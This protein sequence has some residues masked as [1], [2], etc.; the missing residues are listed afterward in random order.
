MQPIDHAY[1]SKYT[2]GNADLENEV[3]CL[4]AEQA[5]VY[6]RQMR[7]AATEKAWREAAHTLKGSARAVGALAVAKCAETAEMATDDCMVRETL[8]AE[9]AEALAT[10][11]AYI[12]SHCPAS[13]KRS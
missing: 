3:L 4:F 2:F 6:L 11:C 7:E 8:L 10:T 12:E 5:P 1:L 9:T 13:I